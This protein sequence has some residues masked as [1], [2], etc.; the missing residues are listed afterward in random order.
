MAVKKYKPTTPGRRN[1][2]VPSFDEITKFEPEKSL[3]KI[4]KKHAGRNSYGRITVRHKGGGNK[5]KYRI[6]DFK[7]A[8][9]GKS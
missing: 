4:L 8:E 2:A 1:M 5:R 9:D 7:R 6:I 3:V